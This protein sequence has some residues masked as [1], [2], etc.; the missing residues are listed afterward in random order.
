MTRRGWERVTL[1]AL[2]T[3]IAAIG[4][5]GAACKKPPAGTSDAAQPSA[6]SSASA[7]PVPEASVLDAS[8]ADAKAPKPAPGPSGEAVLEDARKRV[9]EAAQ[10]PKDCKD[11]LPLLD[12]S[13]SLVRAS[14]ALE[15]GTL[16][17]FAG[18]AVRGGRWRLLRELS[19]E[20]AAGDAAQKTTYLVPRALIGVGEYNTA[21]LLSKATLRAWPKEAEAYTTGALAAARGKDWEGC[22]TATDQALL[23]QRKTGANDVITSLAHALRGAALLHLGKIDDGVHE[24]EAAKDPETLTLAGI[25]LDAAH[26]AKQSGLLVSVDAP[27]ELY[28]SIYPFY[29]KKVAPLSGVATVV[30]ANLTD[31]AMPL[32]VEAALSGEGIDSQ[33]TTVVKGR[34]VTLIMTPPLKPAST[35]PALTA[36]EPHDLTITVNGGPDH[37]VLFKEVTK[38][39]AQPKDQLPVLLRSHGGDFR[40]AFS[41]E[42]AWVTPASPAVV[43]LLDAAKAKAPGGHFEGAAGASFPQVRA[44]WDELR[45]R[46]VSF[47]RDPQ[48]DSE[49]RESEPCRLA[50]EVLGKGTGNALESS[51]LFASLLEAIGLDVILVRTPGH[52]MVAWLPTKGDSGTS[53]AAST[54]KSPLGKAFFLET[55]MVGEGPF[56]A[57]LIRGAAEWVAEV[58]SGAVPAGRSKVESLAALRHGGITPRAE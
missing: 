45:S 17:A 7:H 31:K 3:S 22:K 30:I 26:T 50:T 23:V 41:L 9:A 43:S 42:A 1:A 34:P 58:N 20:I 52:R 47:R 49:A 44:V 46:G 40:S 2:W 33:N 28:P 19:D 14:A 36:A 11:V 37:A 5:L 21:Q 13:Y 35:L 27:D 25:T 56:D 54:I 53:E 38:V 24:I 51:V 55:T 39:T 16:M 15:K 12:V 48:I 18:C 8:P 57:A 6:S 32:L 4:A 10:H 29:G